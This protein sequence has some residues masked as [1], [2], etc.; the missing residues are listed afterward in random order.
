GSSIIAARFLQ[1][2]AGEGPWAHL[3]IASTAYLDRSRD[4]YTTVGATGFGVRLLTELAERT[5]SRA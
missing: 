1:E 3:D 4:Y 2:F 5:A